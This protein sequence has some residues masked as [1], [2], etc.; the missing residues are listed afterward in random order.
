[1]RYN[2]VIEIVRLTL[3]TLT[4]YLLMILSI[5]NDSLKSNKV[6]KLNSIKLTKELMWQDFLSI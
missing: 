6:C 1:M 3:K 2:G 4:F 5:D